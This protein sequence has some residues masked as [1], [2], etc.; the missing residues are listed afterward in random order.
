MKKTVLIFGASSFVGSNLASS[1]VKDSIVY[2]TYF[3][4]NPNSSDFLSFEC[5]IANSKR[6]RAIVAFTKPD[7]IFYCIGKRGVL[8]AA[9]DPV[10]T[11][12]L[13]NSGVF[14]V[15]EAADLFNSKLIFISS[16]F[17]FPGDLKIRSSIENPISNTVYG[18][19]MSSSEFYIRKSCLNYLIIRAPILYGKGFNIKN[20]NI[21][22][23]L[24]IKL[25]CNE[26]VY[27]DDKHKVG[28]LSIKTFC[29][30]VKN[31]IINNLTNITIQ[32][33]SNDYMTQFEFSKLVCDIFSFDTNLLNIQKIDI[34]MLS[35]ISSKTMDDGLGF[36][37]KHD[38][39]VGDVV[40]QNKSIKD[41]LIDFKR[42]LN[43]KK[44]KLRSI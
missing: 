18:S 7:I 3:K 35:A 5:D 39:K 16:A 1:F 21:W 37:L 32:F 12:E 33:S 13:N 26:K 25:S 6:V 20:L 24:N 23:I 2:G 31:A 11:E 41:D 38:E 44:T 43:T 28:F 15:S 29:E 9:K 42:S 27:C 10:I 8:N 30:Y 19:S 22:D 36:F 17:T 4:N 14:H 40:F 34:P